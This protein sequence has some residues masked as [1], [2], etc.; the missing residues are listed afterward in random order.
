MTPVVDLDAYFKRTGYAGS[1]APCL[2]TLHAVTRA[3]VQAIPFENIDVLLGLGVSLEPGAIF[4]KLVAHR[5]GGYCFE[6]NGLLLQVLRQLGFRARA[7]G[8]RVRLRITDHAILPRRTH[9]L[10]EVM[11]DDARWLTDVGIG[12]ASLT[13]ALRLI[14]RLEQRTPHDRR[15][16]LRDGRRWMHQLW[17][18]GCWADVYQFTL[19][20]FP[21]V[22]RDVANWYTSTHPAD[23][24]SNELMGALAL[25]DGGRLTLFNGM[26]K[27]HG[28]GAPAVQHPVRTPAE[29]AW[30][31][32]QLGIALAPDHGLRLAHRLGL[33]AGPPSAE[34][35][36]HNGPEPAPAVPP[37]PA[38]GTDLPVHDDPF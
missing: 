13:Q 33:D 32:E 24:F 11:L 1:H 16:L 10:I 8:A 6:Q 3:H 30:A 19:D 2:H 34:A 35:I 31:L 7:L 9:M 23:S 29:L 28:P 4:G 17:R 37:A 20:A 15:R 26:L 22:D 14:P 5:R 25:P 27:R 36:P 12:A 21:P 18:D 38:S